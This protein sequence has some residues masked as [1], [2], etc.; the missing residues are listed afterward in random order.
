[1]IAMTSGLRINE[2][3]LNPYD[4]CNDCSEWIELYSEEEINLTN[5]KLRDKDNNTMNLNFSFSGYYILFPNISLNNN[6]E[7]LFIYNNSLIFETIE[8][9]DSYNDNQTWQYCDG[10]VFKMNTFNFENNCSSNNQEE[11]EGNVNKKEIK[12]ELNFD[13]ED[14]INGKEFKIDVDFFNLEDELYDVKFWIEY[15][16]EIISERYD[17][18]NEEWKSGNYYLDNFVEGP[19]NKSEKVKI[20][21]KEDI[22]YVGNAI[23]FCKIRQGIEINKDIEIL[24]KEEIALEKIEKNNEDKPKNIKE[25]ITGNVIKLGIS[26]TQDIKTKNSVVYESNNELIKKYSIICFALLC[27][28]LSVLLIKEKL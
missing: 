7:K 1:M 4:D 9:S 18:E 26:K 24:E 5:F 3:E 17:E 6:N 20:K 27:L 22:D 25:K 12:I 23:L 10:W 13:E 15:E 19:G 28:M 11:N 14:I 8:L 16:D 2:V 21:I